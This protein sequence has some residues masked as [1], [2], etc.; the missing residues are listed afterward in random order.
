MG[1]RKGKGSLVSTREHETSAHEERKAR[2]KII[3]MEKCMR[4]LWCVLDGCVRRKGR[5]A[6]DNNWVDDSP[7]QEL[8]AKPTLGAAPAAPRP[9]PLLRGPVV[10]PVPAL[11][12]RVVDMLRALLLAARATAAA[13]RLS[14]RGWC[15]ARTYAAL[16]PVKLH[17]QL[18]CKLLIR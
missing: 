13:G 2:K 15:F 1:E 8:F 4:W 16:S 12:V 11:A 7:E 5:E 10:R 6:G 18:T 9:F 17:L 14:T 3:G